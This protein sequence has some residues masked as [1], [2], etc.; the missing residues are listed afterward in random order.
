MSSRRGQGNPIRH[1]ARN[2][3]SARHVLV[4]FATFLGTLHNNNYY[5]LAMLANLV[6]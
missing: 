3:P 6:Y 1:V 2:S 4:T 5:T